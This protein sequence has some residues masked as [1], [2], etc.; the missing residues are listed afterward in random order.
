LQPRYVIGIGAFAEAR[1]K[2]ALEPLEL[3]DVTYGRI[4]HPSPASPK[5]NTDWAGAVREELK[6]LGLCSCD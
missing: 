1:A 4:L 3:Q 6:Q 5:A 2:I